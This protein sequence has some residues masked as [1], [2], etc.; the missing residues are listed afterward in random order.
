LTRKKV[1]MG[2]KYGS[3]HF[4]CLNCYYGCK[5]H[6]IKVDYSTTSNTMRT[7]LDGKEWLPCMDDDQAKALLE[8][9]KQV[10]N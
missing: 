10:A 3:I 5:G 4:T 6:E 8:A 1:Q 7:Y 2:R 9:L